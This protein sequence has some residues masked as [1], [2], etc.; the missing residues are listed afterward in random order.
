MKQIM[1]HKVVTFLNRQE[2]DI[3]D[4]ISKDILFSKGVK[5][6]RSTILK[7]IIDIVLISQKQKP[8]NYQNVTDLISEKLEKEEK[9]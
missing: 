7:N 8:L 1:L 5:V 2:L 4:N 3:L 6:P 9:K